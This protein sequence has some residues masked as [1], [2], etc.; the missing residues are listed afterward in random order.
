NVFKGHKGW[1]M[2]AKY[3]SNELFNTILSGSDDFSVRLW[4]IRSGQQIQVFN[5]HT[6]R[7]WSVGYSPFVI[8]NMMN[9]LYMIKGDKDD[10]GIFCLKCIVLKKKEN[11]KNVT[12]D[13]NLCYGSGK[14]PI[15]IWG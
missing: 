5:R 8:K 9:Q 2:I 15:R 4:D 1:I 10:N 3:G 6:N 7:V 11:A 14:G 13:L 12:Y